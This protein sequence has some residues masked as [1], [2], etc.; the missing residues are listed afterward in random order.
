MKR[1][2]AVVFLAVAAYA[3]PADDGVPVATVIDRALQQSQITLP[4]SKPFHLIATIVETTDPGSEPRAKIEEYWLSPSKWRRTIASH[5][6]SQTRIVNGDAVSEANT[7]EYFPLWLS[8]MLTAVF[9][10]VPML[11]AI[12]QS[13]WRMPKLGSDRTCADLRMRI[14]RWVIC[15][16]A[17]GLLTSVFT[18]GYFAEFKD[19]K[20][21]AGKSVPRRIVKDPEP[22]TTLELHIDTLELLDSPDETMF[23]VVQ[24][25]PPAEQINTLIVN[26]ETARMLLVNSTEIAWP[27]VGGGVLKGGCAVCFSADRAGHIREVYPAGC[28]NAPLQGFLRDTVLHWQLKPAVSHGVPVQIEALMGFSYQTTLDSAKTVP[29]L[30]D[31]EARRLATYSPEPQFAPRI[32]QSHTELAVRIS[33][34]DTGKFV[35]LQNIH[36]LDGAI[37]NAIDASLLQWKFRPYIKD[38]KPC[39]FNADLIFHAE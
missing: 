39:Q 30:T 31:A 35:G 13:S 10:P 18:K 24:P 21:F 23:A 6:F 4:G 16:D 9:D 29:L 11:G 17:Q 14:D 26:D 12:K 25:T 19:Y 36:K 15:F 33:V 32:A 2:I 27:T 37:L 28:D 3:A 7:G 22:G 34:D 38:G 5:D 8:Q 1:A 20:G